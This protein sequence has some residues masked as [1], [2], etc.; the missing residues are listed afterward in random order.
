MTKRNGITF[1]G[2]ITADR[3]KMIE[4]YPDK[5]MHCTISSET[6]AVGGSVP[7][8]AINLAKLDPTVPLSA[9]GRVG[10]DEGGGYVLGQMQAYGIDTD[11]VRACEAHSTSYTDV[12]TVRSTG[13]RTMF[14][15]RGANAIFSPEDVDPSDL[16]C[17]MLHVGYILL[18]DRFDA[19]DD[20]YGTAMARFLHGVQK[21]GIKTSFDVVS[22]H[23]ADYGA[24]VL[25]AL[26]YTDNAIMNEIECC[27]VAGLAPRDADGAL[28]V[29]NV[30]AAMEVLL[31]H[32]VSERVIVHCPE[33][34]F[35]LNGRGE[36]TRVPSLKLEEGYIKGS[37][38]AGDAFCAGCLYGIYEGYDDRDILR[39]A[40][41]AAACNLSA[42]DSVSGMREKEE[43][44][45]LLERYEA[46]NAE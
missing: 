19:P 34:G 17:R 1:A 31:S 6:L 21:E 32:G 4:G 3:V 26:P 39:F 11:G 18:L 36:F 44:W 28:I 22:E 41:A 2:N 30:R 13:E 37:V 45:A 38:G 5:G 14:H 12:M 15:H 27:A 35:I 43:V 7:N 42:P 40:S 16:T 33:A 24:K 25:P 20:E 8:T 46:K 23:G 9:C 29:E 10:N